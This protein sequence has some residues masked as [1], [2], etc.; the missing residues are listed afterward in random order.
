MSK[1]L[2][3]R[4]QGALPGAGGADDGAPDDGGGGGWRRPTARRSSAR[5]RC[6]GIYRDVRFSKDKTPYR[7][8]RRDDPGGRR[9]AG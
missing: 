3:R 7:T 4:W 9:V 1:P 2:V 5:R 8:H 6:C